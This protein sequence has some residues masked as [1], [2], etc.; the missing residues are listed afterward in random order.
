[1]STDTRAGAQAPTLLQYFHPSRHREV[2]CWFVTCIT[3]Y[4]PPVCD[5]PSQMVS[6]VLKNAPEDIAAVVKAHGN[7]AWDAAAF[8]LRWWESHSPSSRP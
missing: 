6:R 4:G 3:N 7:E 2:A 5:K 8:W 1:M